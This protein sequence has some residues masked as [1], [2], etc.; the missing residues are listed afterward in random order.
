MQPRA[1]S[2]LPAPPSPSL[3]MDP[4]QAV[5]KQAINAANPDNS[6]TGLRIRYKP[7]QQCILCA[8]IHPLH[9]YGGLSG[10]VS[11]KMISYRGC[12]VQNMFGELNKECKCILCSWAHFYFPVKC[13]VLL[14][15]RRVL[16]PFFAVLSVPASSYC[17]TNIIYLWYE[18][19]SHY[20]FNLQVN[21]DAIRVLLHLSFTIM[22]CIM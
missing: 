15:V 4:K 14:R 6:S 12:W 20:L 1:Q 17:I 19:Q 7:Q 9:C 11:G 13:W 21:Y 16:P 18:V 22:P 10:C 8:N 5:L 2:K 3:L